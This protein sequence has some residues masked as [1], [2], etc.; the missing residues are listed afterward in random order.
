[1][2]LDFGQDQ[3]ELLIFLPI[4]SGMEGTNAEQITQKLVMLAYVEVPAFALAV[5][6]LRFE[7]KCKNRGKKT[8]IHEFVSECMHGMHVVGF[9]NF[10]VHSHYLLPLLLYT[11]YFL[12]QVKRPVCT[13]SLSGDSPEAVTAAFFFTSYFMRR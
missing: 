6:P 11:T 3:I 8:Y 5:H 7:A 9:L 10:Y 2:L 13:S 4:L 1:M 12:L